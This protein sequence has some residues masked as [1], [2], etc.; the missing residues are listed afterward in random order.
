MKIAIPN[1][2]KLPGDLE[3]LAKIGE[4]PGCHRCFTTYFIS[5]RYCNF[6]EACEQTCATWL[7]IPVLLST[8]ALSLSLPAAPSVQPVSHLAPHPSVVENRHCTVLQA[9]IAD[10]CLGKESARS[11]GACRRQRHSP[12]R[13]PSSR[14]RSRA[15]PHG[16]WCADWMLGPDWADTLS[17]VLLS[18]NHYRY[19][20]NQNDVS[21]DDE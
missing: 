9:R 15:F 12:R 14:S 10:T 6:R 1:S 16:A 2:H 3:N 17:G 8:V 18:M 13:R 19:L 21:P 5:P 4:F 20:I 11:N 7:A